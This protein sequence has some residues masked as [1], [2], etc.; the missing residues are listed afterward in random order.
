MLGSRCPVVRVSG[1]PRLPVTHGPLRWPCSLWLLTLVTPWPCV[2]VVDPEP[3]VSVEGRGQDRLTRP[4]N[5]APQGSRRWLLFLPHSASETRVPTHMP[6]ARHG[7]FPC[8]HA[9]GGTA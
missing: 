2:R 8:L 4:S 6:T 9:Q 3:A 7:P 1:Q 5:D